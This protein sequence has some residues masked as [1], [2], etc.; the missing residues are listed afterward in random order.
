MCENCSFLVTKNVLTVIIEK[1][2]PDC[3]DYLDF[4]EKNKDTI[5]LAYR[6]TRT[7]E[8]SVGFELQLTNI[9]SLLFECNELRKTPN[10]NLFIENV[11]NFALFFVLAKIHYNEEGKKCLVFTKTCRPSSWY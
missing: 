3:D 9:P 4:V 7:P 5:A 8:P 2:V 6:E 1:D 10:I 11:D